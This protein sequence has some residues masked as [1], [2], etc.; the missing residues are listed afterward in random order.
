MGDYI[1]DP[2]HD[3]NLYTILVRDSFIPLTLI[4]GASLSIVIFISRSFAGM[5]FP[6]ETFAAYFIMFFILYLAYKKYPRQG[7]FR[8]IIFIIIMTTF[9]IT[10]TSENEPLNE[11]IMILLFP[12]LA[13]HLAGHKTGSLWIVFFSV[14]IFTII[15][16]AQT[17]ILHSKYNTV[18]LMTGF[19]IFIYISILS[20]Y[21]ELRHGTIEKLLMRQLYYDNITGLPNRKMLMEDI[22]LILYP[23][24]IIIK[25]DNFHDVN[26][27]FGYN[28]G[29]NILKFIGER[30]S[31]FR[32]DYNLKIYNLT[33]GE[34]AV[35][36]DMGKTITN[37]NSEIS[38]VAGELLKHISEKEFIYKDIKIP[39]T[40]YA[41]IAPSSEGTDNLISKAD[42]ALH[43]A[44]RNRMPIHIYHENDRDKSIYLRNIKYLSQLNDAVA[45]DCLVPYFQPI[46]NNITSEIYKHES[47]LRIIDPHGTP[48]FPGPYLNVARQTQIYPEITRIIFEKTFSYM[49][50]KNLD[51]ALNI[52]ADDIYYPGFFKFIQTMTEKFPQTKG[53][54]I[55]EIVESEN[56]SDYRFLADF[57]KA[58]KKTGFRFAID[59]FGTGY[60]N[61]SYLSRLHLDYIKF[62]GSLINKIDSDKNSRIIIRNISA[63]CRELGIKTI[64]EFVEN[65]N[66]FNQVRDY[67]IDYSQG[68][69]IGE[70]SPSIIVSR[71]I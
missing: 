65:E 11:F 8:L 50:D 61:F 34:F 39:L 2:R 14:Y 68:F 32:A 28:L 24:L 5:P 36:A 66:I 63:L 60:S 22:P 64:A 38:V 41:G 17:G 69:Y 10:V 12:V 48:L 47:L 35:I 59:D 15:L 46:M 70:P 23:S 30:I 67:G 25:I 45:G 58:A 43:H 18:T 40:A 71:R 1:I 44:I 52:S 27:F 20:Y 29:D 13:Y 6:P 57:I 56:F 54:V 62:D 4:L 33:G 49:Q 42:I 7:L 53:R 21:A 9:L 51:F 37:E 31:G 26:T 19:S 3:I 16:L 55:L